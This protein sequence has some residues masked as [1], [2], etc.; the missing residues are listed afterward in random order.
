M[1]ELP[2]LSVY[3]LPRPYLS[4]YPLFFPPSPS[5]KSTVFGGRPATSGDASYAKPT[6]FT[7]IAH[8]DADADAVPTKIVISDAG[9]RIHCDAGD[10]VLEARLG[11]AAKWG[12]RG[13]MSLLEMLPGMPLF[14]F[15]HSLHSP[16]LEYTWK[17]KHTGKVLMQVHGKRMNRGAIGSII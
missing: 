6:N 13:P 3:S 5:L 9:A 15:V 8:D 14:W 4:F 17:E 7:F 2:L 10:A 11:G 1:D 12:G 16:V